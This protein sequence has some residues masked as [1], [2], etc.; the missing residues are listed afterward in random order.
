MPCHDLSECIAFGRKPMAERT[1]FCKEKGLC[2]KCGQKHIIKDCQTDVKCRKCDS[3]AHASFMHPLTQQN[4][5]EHD[6]PS[7][8]TDDKK[9]G[10]PEANTKCTRYTSCVKARSCSKIV[11][12]KVYYQSNP[13]LQKLMPCVLD[14][15][16]NACLRDPKL[17]D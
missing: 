10:T 2:F 15:Q 12:V 4:G 13:Y 8:G 17:F 5:G 6:K 14:D 7:E 16:S 11:L 3:E 9:G 1:R